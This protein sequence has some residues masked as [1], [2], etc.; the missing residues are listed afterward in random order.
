[1]NFPLETIY[2]NT[3]LLTFTKQKTIAVTLVLFLSNYHQFLKV[4]YYDNQWVREI[5]VV[6]AAKKLLQNKTLNQ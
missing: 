2:L 3:I 1:M 6:A 5:F 4:L